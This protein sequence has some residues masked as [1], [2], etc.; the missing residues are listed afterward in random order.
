MA[1]SSQPTPLHVLYTLK[2][3]RSFR[4]LLDA[5][6]QSNSSHSGGGG[7]SFPRSWGVSSLGPVGSEVNARDGF[8]RT[9][10]HLAAGSLDGWTLE[11]VRIC[12]AQKG[13]DVNLQDPESGW[14][15]LH[16]ALY[17]GNLHAGRLLMERADISLRNKDHEDYTPW[18][19]YNMTLEGTYPDFDASYGTMLYTWGVNRNFTLGL[20]D[21]NDRT[22]PESIN[23]ARLTPPNNALGSARFQTL[24]VSSIVMSKLH[25]GIVTS[26]PRANIR[27]C[28]FGSGGRLGAGSHTQYSFAP[29]KDFAHTVTALALGQDHTLAL[30]SL[31]EVYSWGLGRFGQLGYVIE[32]DDKPA[33][34]LADSEQVQYS[35]K[36]V[37]GPL[38]G[39]EARGVAACKTASAA[40]TREG[41]YTWGT[42][43]GQLGY[44]RHAVPS[45]ISPRKVT[46]VAQ[47]V[48]DVALAENAM[49]VL[50]ESQDV[51]C[52][53]NDT[54]FKV[55]F[56][57]QKFRNESSVY[58]PPQA[59]V[60]VMIQKLV[61]C[62][63][64]FV[65]LSTFGDVFFFTLPELGNT[66]GDSEKFVLKPQRI[67]ATRSA[68]SM[69]K[70]VGLG[71]DGTVI[72]CSATGHVF[73]RQRNVKP[74]GD[75]R[76]SLP[77]QQPPGPGNLKSFKFHRVPWLQRVIRV[78]ANSTG[79]FGAISVDALPLGINVSGP[80]F[81]EQL[82]KGLPHLRQLAE[83][84]GPAG[85]EVASPLSSSAGDLS[86]EAI[87]DEDEDESAAEAAELRT[88]CHVVEAF[89]QLEETKLSQVT[90]SEPI[91]ARHLWGADVSIEVAG[92]TIFTHQ[93]ILAARSRV[94]R[95]A[96]AGQAY[97]G[98]E[99]AI[100]LVKNAK[101]PVTRLNVRL[102]TRPAAVMQELQDLP[103]V[104]HPLSI[105]LLLQYLY[106]DN[107]PSLWDRHVGERL[108]KRY[109][110]LKLHGSRMRA[111]LLT[112]ARALELPSLEAFMHAATYARRAPA[113]TLVRD[114]SQLFDESQ[115][116]GHKAK[117][118][119]VLQLNDR[120][121]HCHSTL[122][123]ARSPFFA[124]MF[125]DEEWMADRWSN[126]GVVEV[127]MKHLKWEVMEKVFAFIYEDQ[128]V[129]MFD[130]VL[131]DTVDEFIDYVFHV[132]AVASELLLDKLMLICSSVILR[133]VSLYN[134]PSLLADAAHL[135]A[136][137]LMNS[138][139]GYI[140]MNLESIM[141]SR[142][143]DE[144]PHDLLNRLGEHVRSMQAE[145][146]PVARSG[147]L[148]DEAMK[149]HAN[150]LLLEDFPQ[151]MQR[152]WKKMIKQSPRLSPINPMS[153]KISPMIKPRTSPPSNKTAHFKP[154]PVSMPDDGGIFAM[155]EDVETSRIPPI[156]LDVP[157]VSGERTA[158]PLT[159]DR[160][161]VWKGKSLQAH[162]KA[163]MRSIMAEEAKA[164]GRP[165]L[166]P[167]GSAP[168]G[169]GL[170]GYP[171]LSTP[172]KSA[173]PPS[174]PKRT[175]S[176][177]SL[178]TA[179]AA[180]SAPTTPL[181]KPVMRSAMQRPGPSMPG[182]TPTGSQPPPLEAGV[183]QPSFKGPAL[184]PVITPVRAAPS[185]SSSRR[186]NQDAWASFAPPTPPP[187]SV[188]PPSA[189]PS[190]GGVSF[191]A[192]QQ[193]Q[194]AAL[195]VGV[196]G[197]K[198]PSLLEIQEQEKAR[199]QEEQ[200]SREEVEFM[201]W[202]AQEEERIRREGATVPPADGADSGRGGRGRGRGGRG[203]GGGTDSGRGARG[204][205]RGGPPRE[206]GKGPSQAAVGA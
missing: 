84:R 196:K 182:P 149:T 115:R 56:P 83:S 52:F 2:D 205:R 38:K 105:L 49:C 151:P 23:L 40:W 142:L 13:V 103:L 12:L 101:G 123:R 110:K 137:D 62:E 26:E 198:K 122:L 100:A 92:C 117:Y 31:G 61:A 111:E 145:Q 147:I 192:I 27:L 6:Q 199:K 93:A 194:K 112:L 55:N 154:P 106:S 67:W 90:K 113:P 74:A 34:V 46:A 88:A 4:Q 124:S 99:V 171:S 65:A 47:G 30:T 146:S 57:A 184:G 5:R 63:N 128:G 45:Q 189:G 10:L 170:P 37:L 202:W 181:M 155:D 29:L 68:E 163:D 185:E 153:P 76:R 70:D 36:K 132:M 104:F 19:V 140:A 109:S 179:G 177:V 121:V 32:K 97:N 43:A 133:H 169:L 69:A 201:Q 134:V 102:L 114:M 35:P 108:L 143:L 11:W 16:R 98:A 131:R 59:I 141:E 173:I 152:S 39:K 33:P 116:A 193:E 158:S 126:E 8:G 1:L 41:L 72:L 206:K 119:M 157:A 73:V 60:K 197:P 203:K 144:M 200:I 120:S 135:S 75:G 80:T 168:K 95:E 21:G 138:L 175:P 85:I 91:P 9:L 7:S 161:A 191:L 129:E 180:G 183:R 89:I 50:L 96:L 164:T 150:W 17:V 130:N 58:R 25:T 77:G 172:A 187:M 20:G 148:V 79:A 18:D 51:L 107:L 86:P 53:W 48:L 174:A 160:A 204:S 42:N 195:V 165:S 14:T 71:A 24:G 81:G 94:F 190:T 159:P 87:A 118:D 44:D 167:T 188:S 15:A 136:R 54:H 186:R 78:S 139:C 66:D 22:H 64:T 176:G 3:V 127:N 178:S 28:G 82:V 166:T 162:Q 125:D 156:S